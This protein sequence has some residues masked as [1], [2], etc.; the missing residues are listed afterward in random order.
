MFATSH[1]HPM[2]VHFPIALVLIGFLAELAFLV[3]KNE[4]CLTKMGYYL[5]IIGTL[6]AFVS[7]LSGQLFTSDMEGAAEKVRSLHELLATTTFVFLII[8]ASLRS[9]LLVKKNENKSLKIIAFTL[10]GASAILVSLTGFMG[11]N[12]VYGYMMPL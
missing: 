9:Y 8:T 3:I 1:L 2:L 6:A 12:L 4:I 10:Y 11:G 5:L 7:W